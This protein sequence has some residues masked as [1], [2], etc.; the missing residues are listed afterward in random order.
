MVDD[1]GDCGYVGDEV[2]NTKGRIGEGRD[3]AGIDESY[4]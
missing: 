1:D 4:E 2:E 3:E